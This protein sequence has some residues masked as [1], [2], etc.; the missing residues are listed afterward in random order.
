MRS[1]NEDSTVGAIKGDE[2]RGQ[3]P[4]KPWK[5]S[6]QKGSLS[7]APGGFL[8]QQKRHSSGPSWTHETQVC[9]R[10]GKSPPH[11]RAQCP[12]KDAV[13]HWCSKKGHFKNTCR[14][15]RTIGDSSGDE[16]AFLSAVTTKEKGQSWTVSLYLN[17]SL[18]EFKIDTGANVTVIPVSAYNQI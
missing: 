5:G 2:R 7:N 10:C 4:H 13:C 17:D 6:L 8:L 9:S 3:P 11:D 16:L 1:H 15:K 18:K 12:A 14:S